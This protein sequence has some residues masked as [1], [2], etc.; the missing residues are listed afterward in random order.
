[1]KPAESVAAFSYLEVSNY[2]IGNAPR[3]LGKEAKDMPL[4]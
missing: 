4:G 3:A 1:M 2:W